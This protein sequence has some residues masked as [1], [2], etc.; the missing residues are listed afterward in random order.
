M[1]LLSQF[2]PLPLSTQNPHSLSHS[3]HHCSCPWVIHLSSLATPPFPILYFTSSWLFCN[4]L[5]VLIN[6]LTLSLIPSHPLPS[7]N[8]QN[9][10][11]IHDSVSV[12]LVCLLC[13]LD[14]IVDRCVCAILLFIVWIFFLFLNK[15]L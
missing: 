5:F 15:S 3:P 1:L 4:F 14:S 13:L 7:G 9:P 6:P 8:R 2:P 11:R 10:L 12:F